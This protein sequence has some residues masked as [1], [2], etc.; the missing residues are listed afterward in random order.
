MGELARQYGPRW[1]QHRFHEARKE[2]YPFRWMCCGV[3]G[4]KS[5]AGLE[6][7]WILATQVYPG[8]SG[9]IVVTGFN[10]VRDTFAPII[11]RSW[12]RG[13]YEFKRL[14]QGPSIVIHTPEGDSTVYIRSSKDAGTV[15]DINSLTVTWAHLD[16]VA[17][18]RVGALA[19]KYALGRCREP[20]SKQEMHVTS[21]PR[22]GW[23]PKEFGVAGGIPDEG[24]SWLGGMGYSP[25]PGYWVIQA[26]S[27]ENTYNP[28][29]YT[30]L[31]RTVYGDGVFGRQE[32][33]G[34]IEGPSGLI[35]PEF[36]AGFHVI[37]DTIAQALTYGLSREGANDW[38]WGTCCNLWGAWI[39]H[40]DTFVVLG[41]WYEHG[42]HDEEQIAHAAS[43]PDVAVWWGDSEDPG[44]IEKARHGVTS[45]G[46]LHR[47]NCKPA[48]KP[49]RASAGAVRGLL[50]R[51]PG[52]KHPA[53]PD[54]DVGCP[55]L[56]ISA[57]CPNLIREL[58]ELRSARDDDDPRPVPDHK[59]LGD[60][61]ACD[62]LRYVIW[63]SE[64][65][66]ET[67]TAWLP[68]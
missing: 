64:R 4:G 5:W 44:T 56:L 3:G 20:G 51:R 30:Q 63:N 8:R 7:D 28:E 12:P 16:E 61:H 54:A 60:D 68:I 9:L 23:L 2:G 46:R 55:R 57:A 27:E 10:V 66:T 21:S 19:W 11:R 15:D 53:F 31:M 52:V 58:G 18:S 42:R 45:R 67:R 17:R 33:D 32:L 41:E 48:E 34:S 36:A 29:S 43:V 49:F 13:A 37:P 35:F 62:A 1:H 50:E 25:K 47:I 6:E 22:P 14:N 40:G 39:E 59:T 38:G 65:M 24:K 26:K